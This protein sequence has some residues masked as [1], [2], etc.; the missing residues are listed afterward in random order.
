MPYRLYIKDSQKLLGD[1]T[2]D[3]VQTLVELLEEEDDEDRDYYIDRDMLDFMQ[4]EGADEKLLDMIRPHV[5]EEEGVEIEWRDE[6]AD[7]K[8]K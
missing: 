3:Q 7:A 2:E 8:A 1:L 4:E 6:G 5:G